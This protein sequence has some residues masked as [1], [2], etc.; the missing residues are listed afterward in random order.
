M[1]WASHPRQK[2]GGGVKLELIIFEDGIVIAND[3]GDKTAWRGGLSPDEQRALMKFIQDEQQFAG[4]HSNPDHQK[5]VLEK[6]LLDIPFAQKLALDPSQ[7]FHESIQ[8]GP[9]EFKVQPMY[10][11]LK[12][13]TY[14]NLHPSKKFESIIRRLKRIKSIT[15]IGGRDELKFYL[16]FANREL[17]KQFPHARPLTLDDEFLAH[18]YK[19]KNTDSRD[20]RWLEFSLFR[21]RFAKFRSNTLP[22]EN[23]NCTM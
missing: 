22:S 6:S 11:V 8:V 21:N 1:I 3:A 9:N 4:I 23:L 5:V 16:E 7:T 10:S 20:H 2:E 17:F 19:K 13:G 15:L 12:S 18:V 14:T